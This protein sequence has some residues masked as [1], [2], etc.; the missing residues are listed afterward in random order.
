MTDE[1]AVLGTSKVV[2]ISLG[3][4]GVFLVTSTDNFEVG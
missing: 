2:L 3:L 4:I 1:K